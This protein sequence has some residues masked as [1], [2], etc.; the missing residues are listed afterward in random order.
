MTHVFIS[1]PFVVTSISKSN[2][3]D[4]LKKEDEAMSSFTN[5][6]AKDLPTIYWWLP[7]PHFIICLSLSRAYP[8]QLLSMYQRALYQLNRKTGTSQHC[9]TPVKTPQKA[10]L[11]VATKPAYGEVANKEGITSGI[12]GRKLCLQNKYEAFLRVWFPQNSSTEAQ[13]WGRLVKSTTTPSAL[14]PHKQQGNSDIL[15]WFLLKTLHSLTG[16]KYRS[17][18]GSKQA[19]QVPTAVSATMVKAAGKLLGPP[20]HCKHL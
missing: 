4:S 16:E 14:L 19:Q 7:I 3:S 11:C 12:R 13:L 15:V 5:L 6:N 8:K 9:H 20:G 17:I 10:R 1:L 18:S 2:L